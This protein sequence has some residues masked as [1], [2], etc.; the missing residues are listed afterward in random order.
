MIKAAFATV[1]FKRLHLGLSAS[2][3][4]DSLML[5][6]LSMWVKRL[7]DSNG[8]AGL[9]FLWLTLPA[10]VAPLFGYV[11]DRVPRRVF[12]VWANIG[13]ALAVLP[14]LLVRDAS[15][16]WI[17]YSVA[18]CYGV[19]FVVVPAALNGLLK[20]MLPEDVLVE[21]NASL[22]ITREAFR[23]VGPL[24][25][26]TLFALAGGAWVAAID[27]VTFL[28]AAAA[29]G[30]LR[31]VE[32]RE[33]RAALHW[34]AEVAAGVTHI[35]RTPTLLHATLSL[36]ICLLVLGFSESAVYA[37]V[38]AFDKPVEFVGPVLSVQGAG[39]IVS[40]LLSS[41]VIRLLGEP[42]AIIVGLLLLAAGLGGVAASTQVWMLL[43]A[44]AVLGAGIPVLIVAYNTM[45]QKQ[46]PGHLMGRVS[47]ATEVLVTT[48]QA[49]SIATGALLVTLV[50]WRLMFVAMTA[51]S[52]LA[53]VYLATMLR[54]RL[55]PVGGRLPE[56]S[57]IVE[58]RGAPDI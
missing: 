30:S 5:I 41:R 27:A 55:D 50:D 47:T 48:P 19:S 43:A 6:V 25:G 53:A 57:V 23:L 14:L 51:G 31:V 40:G 26:A 58:V 32:Q 56:Q 11:V 28:V 39:A 22:S 46:T 37:V 49:L 21:A 36:S 38:E 10:L 35:R 20:D 15:D 8:A 45:L 54:G 12:L 44:T 24:A 1:G 52:L 2:M 29:I 33:E 13:S 4:G 7:T 34:R 17:I 42:K 3:F 18:F 16:V 9:T